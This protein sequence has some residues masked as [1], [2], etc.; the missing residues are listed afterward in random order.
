MRN[1]H[2][3]LLFLFG[4][5][6]TASCSDDNN[7]SAGK[8]Q[9]KV[10]GLSETACY[11][12]SIFFTVDCSDAEGVPLSTLKAYVEYSGEQ[13]SSQVTRTMNAGTYQVALYAPMYKKVPDGKVVIRLVL[14]NIQ[15]TMT[16]N[17][18]DITLTRPKYESIKFVSSTGTIVELKPDASNPY[19]FKGIYNSA[20]KTFKGHFVAPKKGKHGT[21]ISFG[22]GNEEVKELTADDITFTGR[23]GNNTVSFNVYTYEYGPTPADAAAA[24]EIVLTKTD[25][26]YVGEL[27]QGHKYEFSGESV[28]NSDSWFH[29]SDWF[30][31]NGDG[32]YT[33]L[34]ITGTYSLTADFTNSGFRIWTMDGNKSA[35]LHADGTGA[36]WIIG[37]NGV[38]K[39][40]Y[41]ASHVQSWWTGED[42]NYCLTPIAPKVHQITLTV[43]KQLRSTDVNFKFFGQANWGIEFK[44]TPADYH[45]STSSDIFLIG[46]GAGGHDN[47]NIY[48]KEGAE[49]HDGDTY[50]FKVDLTQGTANGILTITKL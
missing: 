15:Q 4:L 1:I 48:L 42:R 12:D 19:L 39:P 30:S 23:K 20:Y 11:G 49:L 26:I 6:I 47:G 33:F 9:M 28:I 31:N 3:L 29:D 16:E 10:N 34:A 43:G 24:T 44:G 18:I 22:Q 13:V 27:I 35:S 7:D 45:L 41:T 17:C 21:E 38:G 37:N 25:N 2:Y 8:P 14:Q 36:I 50:V 32:T 40:G 46:E 5:L